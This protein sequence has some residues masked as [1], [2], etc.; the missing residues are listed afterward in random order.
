MLNQTILS[1]ENVYFSNVI[2]VETIVV[3]LD[4]PFKKYQMTIYVILYQA[5]FYLITTILHYGWEAKNVS[6]ASGEWKLSAPLPEEEE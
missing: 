1:A 2:R 3:D 6:L 5:I 4:T